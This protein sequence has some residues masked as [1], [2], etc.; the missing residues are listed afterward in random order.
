MIRVP[1]YRYCC[2]SRNYRNSMAPRQKT[3]IQVESSLLFPYYTLSL[4][5]LLSPHS[6]SHPHP[7]TSFPSLLPPFL[8]LFPTFSF[9]FPPFITAR[10]IAE[11]HSSP[12]RSGR[13]PAAKRMC[14]SQPTICKSI[15]KCVV[16]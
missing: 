10:G 4:P 15:A 8:L 2:Q 13:S 11:R 14:N 1:C 6:P 7:F 9:A 3:N 5:L 16:M 12:S